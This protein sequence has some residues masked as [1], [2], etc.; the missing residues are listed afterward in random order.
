MQCK[1]VESVIP[2]YLK[3]EET[4]TVTLIDSH[5]AECKSCREMADLM[6]SVSKNLAAIPS[7]KP[8][9]GYLSK[10][11]SRI[12]K[13]VPEVAKGPGE[14][15]TRLEAVSKISRRTSLSNRHKA[16]IRNMSFA[17]KINFYFLS[18]IR[19]PA[20]AYAFTIH[21]V[22]LGLCIF[23]YKSETKNSFSEAQSLRYAAYDNRIEQNVDTGK[24]KIDLLVKNGEVYITQN[25]YCIQVQLN[26]PLKGDY[27]VAHV[28][29]GEL[30]L[31]SSIVS[32]YFQDKEVTI[33]VFNGAVEV[34]SK[35]SFE[36]YILEEV[37]LRP[38]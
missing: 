28:V 24:I 8:E 31:E 22:V 32:K 21:M 19:T 38:A 10:I 18:K 6:K 30:Q 3:G 37:P 11:H 23:L 1:E 35:S 13:S 17:E 29:N 14:T 2:S 20:F 12:Q 33:L 7:I 15:T 5:L 26:K 36:K 16:K 9:K 4:E 34:W 27:D 25:K